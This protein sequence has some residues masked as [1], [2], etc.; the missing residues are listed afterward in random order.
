MEIKMNREIRDYQEN[1]FFGLNLRQLLCSLLAVGVAVGVYFGLRDALGAE[2][3]GWVCILCAAPFAALGFVRYNGMTAE[4]ILAAVICSELL[5]P[6]RLTFRAE[7]IYYQ[8]L[9]PYLHKQERPPQRKKRRKKKK[10][11]RKKDT[12]L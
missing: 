1:I 12:R 5:T 3:V 10:A 4:K 7:N 11:I 2:T 8:A 6:K 9:E